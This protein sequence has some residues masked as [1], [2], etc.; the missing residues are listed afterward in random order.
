MNIV[1]ILTTT[2]HTPKHISWLKQR[3]SLERK[4]MYENVIKLWLDKSNFKIVVVENS[5]CRFDIPK[6]DNL[7][8]LSFQYPPEHKSILDQMEAK[9]Q[10]EMYSL[11]YACLHSKFISQSDFMIKITGRYFIPKLEEYLKINLKNDIECIRQSTRWRKMNR[12]ELVGCHRRIIDKIFY[13]PLQDDM[14][15]QEMMDRMKAYTNILNLPPLLLHQ[16]TRQGVG[17]LIK[18][19]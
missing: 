5:G 6:N 19:I 16:P 1:I 2:V 12:C 10:H 9:G 15:E 13:F 11:Q 7:E 14:M 4:K 18:N 17:H 3:D 8:I